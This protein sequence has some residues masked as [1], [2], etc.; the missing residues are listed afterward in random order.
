MIK[1]SIMGVSGRMGKAI[2]RLLDA[3]DD[4]QIVGA[5]EIE[6]HPDMG[7]DV[8]LVAGEEEIGV[9]ITSG[10]ETACG[11]ADVIVDFT[12]PS[13][14]LSNASFAASNGIAMIIGTTGFDDDREKAY[15]WPLG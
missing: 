1:V 9:P 10:I 13:S 2:Y 12:A 15:P 4:I 14:T 8:G 11:Q 3:E 6:S 7:K 5:T